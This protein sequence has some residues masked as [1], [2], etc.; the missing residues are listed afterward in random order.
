MW[1]YFKYCKFVFRKIFVLL[2]VNIWK[3]FI[4]L[5]ISDLCCILCFLGIYVLWVVD[6]CVDFRLIGVNGGFFYVYVVFFDECSLNR[7]N[8]LGGYV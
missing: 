1:K 4:I 7:R 3:K 2:N 8:N 5:I 6:F